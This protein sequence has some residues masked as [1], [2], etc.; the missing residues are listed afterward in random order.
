[1]W[2]YFY[3]TVSAGEIGTL[4]QLRNVIGRTNV[5][6]DPVH[7]FNEC[8]DFFRLVVTCHVLVSAMKLLSMKALDDI[9]S[10]PDDI[11]ATDLWMETKEKRKEILQS[12]C[13]KIVNDFVQ[14]KFKNVSLPSTDKV[15]FTIYFSFINEAITKIL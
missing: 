8:D 13:M 2:K 4:F 14:F 9:P 15:S 3:S 11:C 12:L 7:R 5:N 6:A 10:L 1:M